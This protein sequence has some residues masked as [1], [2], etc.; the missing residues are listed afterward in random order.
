MNKAY[1]KSSKF[2]AS[3]FPVQIKLSNRFFYTQDRERERETIWFILSFETVPS[4]LQ[5]FK[6][7]QIDFTSFESDRDDKRGKRREETNF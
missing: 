3:S 4:H 7:N 2:D 6:M 1:Y 5:Q